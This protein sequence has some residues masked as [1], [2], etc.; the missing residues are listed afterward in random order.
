MLAA[1]WIW[2]SA[3]ACYAAFRLWYDNWRG[4]L[5]PDEVEAFMARLAQSPAAA[6]NDLDTLRAFL[7]RDD[8]REFVMLN[9][10]R[11]NPEPV[12]HPTTGAPVPAPQAM[13]SYMRDFLPLLLRRGGHPAVV[14]RCIGGYVDA[15]NAGPDPGW[16]LFGCMR[17]R[18]RRDMARLATDPRFGAAHAFKFAAMPVTFS[19]P[20]RLELLLYVSPRVW[21]G[22]LLALA[23]ALAHL[24]WLATR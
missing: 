10:V 24:A 12:P 7:A 1:A 2:G 18:S 23:A 3:L 9:L 20:T 14:G 22:L 4:P 6:H 17:Y 21:V 5:R 11:L 8:G 19:F 15:W 16:T 13:R